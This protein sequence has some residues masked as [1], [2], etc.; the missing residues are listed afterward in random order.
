VVLPVVLS[1]SIVVRP[2]HGW[3]SLPLPA[4]WA[5][6]SVLSREVESVN[7]SKVFVHVSPDVQV[8]NGNVSQNLLTVDEE[9]SSEGKTSLFVKDSVLLRNALV[10]IREEINVKVAT[11][12]SITR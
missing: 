6:V 10:E 2:S 3:I 4:G 11:E 9:G 5:D 7:Q 8:V 1:L 12:S